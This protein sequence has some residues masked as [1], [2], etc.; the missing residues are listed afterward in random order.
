MMHK[1]VHFAVCFSCSSSNLQTYL[2]DNLIS[3]HTI[4]K[5]KY[6]VWKRTNPGQVANIER[7]SRVL[8]P[9]EKPSVI[10]TME[11][12]PAGNGEISA[13]KLAEIACE[14]SS[15]VES[16]TE[17]AKLNT[18]FSKDIKELP[19][20]K[21]EVK[22]SLIDHFKSETQKEYGARTE[23]KAIWHYEVQENE[24]VRNTNKFVKRKLGTLDDGTGVLVGGRIDGLNEKGRVVEVKNRMKR[25]FDPLPKY[26]IAQESPSLYS[27]IMN[28]WFHVL[29]LGGLAISIE[30][31]CP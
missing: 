1:I 24:T 18:Y 30:P 9:K 26:D 2:L 15:N 22:E 11:D 16:G 5:V 28:S 17:L 19:N 20:V 29:S 25:F 3:K 27:F 14:L 13:T 4:K 21:E 31:F 6:D 8:T 23:H 12:S 7:Q 10:E